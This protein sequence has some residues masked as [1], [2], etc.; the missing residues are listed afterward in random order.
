MTAAQRRALVQALAAL[1]VADVR[2][3][4]DTVPS[5]AAPVESDA[6]PAGT[7][8]TVV[9]RLHPRE[10]VGHVRQLPEQAPPPSPREAAR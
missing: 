2:R 4:P 10:T 6:S 8:R 9:G 3:R 5:E 7:A 1:L